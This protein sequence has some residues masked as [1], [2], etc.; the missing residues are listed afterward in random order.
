[1]RTMKTRKP[2]SLRYGC[3]SALGQL[4]LRQPAPFT[5]FIATVI[6]HGLHRLDA[7]LVGLLR[8]LGFAQ[9]P[10]RLAEMIQSFGVIRPAIHIFLQ[11]LTR[12]LMHSRGQIC[13]ADL[14]PDLALSELVAV[15]DDNVE[16]VDGL[17]QPAFLSGDPAKL[18]VGV[19]FARVNF[20]GAFETRG[21]F[22]E[23][24][25]LLIDQSEL[26]MRF[27]V[28]LVDRA[29]FELAAETL[30]LAEGCTHAV[31]GPQK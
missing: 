24:A 3:Q 8:A 2:D 17:L 7:L 1:G 28:A 21:G 9:V 19:G 10:Q 31:N 23:L 29:G 26:V 5:D 14:P 12:L 18:E 15:S 16:M 30:A 11:S 13:R 25:A 27:R 4:R 6:G 20:G 22:A